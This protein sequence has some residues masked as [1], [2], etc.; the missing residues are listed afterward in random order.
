MAAVNRTETVTANTVLT[1][2]TIILELSAVHA[3]EN[4]NGFLKWCWLAD[5]WADETTP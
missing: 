5:Y 2:I 4:G 1:V 3:A